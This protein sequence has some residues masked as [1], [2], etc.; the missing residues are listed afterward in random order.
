MDFDGAAV[1]AAANSEAGVGAITTCDV[2]TA[3]AVVCDADSGVAGTEGD[4][5]EDRVNGNDDGTSDGDTGGVGILG[6]TC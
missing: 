1:G 6:R 2:A 4:G 3:R 5:T